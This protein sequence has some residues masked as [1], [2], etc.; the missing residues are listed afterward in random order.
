MYVL[1]EHS[2]SGCCRTDCERWQTCRIEGWILGC[3]FEKKN[4][5]LIVNEF[6]WERVTYKMSGWFRK[7]INYKKP[8][9]YRSRDEE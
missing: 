6:V 1:A 5:V 7:G 2:D 9:Y 8:D 3:S 4:A